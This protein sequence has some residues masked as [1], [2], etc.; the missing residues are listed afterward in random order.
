M[1]IVL[2]K[3]KIFIL[4]GN[5]DVVEPEDGEIASIE[6]VEI[7]QYLL[8]EHWQNIHSLMKKN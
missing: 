8:L 4:S 2:N 6:V 1:M 3:E 5:G 7:L